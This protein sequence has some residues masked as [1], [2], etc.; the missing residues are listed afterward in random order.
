MTSQILTIRQILEGVRPQNLEATILRVDFSK[1]FDSL[2]K[3]K[4]E[5]VLFAYGLPKETVAA[6][7]ML[8]KNTNVKARSLDGDRDYFDIAASVL[9]GDTLTP[10]LFIIYLDYVLRTSIDKMKDNSF[11]LAEERS[12]RY[13]A[14]TNTDADYADARALL[15][16][17]PD[18]TEYL[19][20]SLE[21]AAAGIGLHVNADK[22]RGNISTLNGSSLKLVDKFTNLRSSVSSTETDT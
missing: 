5:Q 20:H 6:I 18:Q 1:A 17:T 9:Q 19:L 13:P 4:M 14:Q 3:G 15:T 2:H 10:F 7:M 11:E 22:T 12:G 21:R 16:N 8:Y